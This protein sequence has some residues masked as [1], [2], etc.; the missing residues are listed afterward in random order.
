[1]AQEASVFEKLGGSEGL[2]SNTVYDIAEDELGFLWIGTKSGL[3]RFDGYDFDAVPLTYSVS[4]VPTTAAVLSLEVDKR[5]LLWIG[6]KAGG[7]M[8]YDRLDHTIR[9]YPFDDNKTVDWSTITIRSIYEDSRGW[10]W[11]G[12]FGGGAIVLDTDRKVQAHYCTYCNEERQ[13]KLSNDFV[14]DFAEDDNGDIYIA[15]A[16]RGLNRYSQDLGGVE[17]VHAPVAKDLNSFGKTLCFDSNGILWIGTE[18]NG[19]YTFD[20]GRDIWDVYLAQKDRL[21]SN[22]ITDIKEDR[23]GRLWVA[24]DGGGLNVYDPVSDVFRSI[25]YDPLRPNS[26]TTDAIYDLHFDRGDN[27]WIGTFNS[28]V[29]SLK[30]IQSPFWTDREYDM[31]RRKGLRSVLSIQEDDRNRV[32]L[33]TDGGGLF[34]FNTGDA[35]LNLRSGTDLIE[36]GSFTDVVTSILPDEDRGI[37]FGSFAS[38]LNYYDFTTRRIRQYVHDDTIATS[39]SHNNVWDIEM[40]ESGDLWIATLGGGL[41]YLAAGTSAFKHYPTLLPSVQIID[42]EM[43]KSNR[44]LWAATEAEGLYR[45][46]LSSM[47]VKAYRKDGAAD[48]RLRSDMLM[49]IFDDDR[50]DLWVVHAAGLDRIDASDGSITPIDLDQVFPMSSLRTVTQ[51]QEGY[52]W[53]ATADGIFRL[54]RDSGDLLDFGVD[55]SLDYNSYNPRAVHLLSDGRIIFGG[56]QSF[57]IVQPSAVE[58]NGNDAVPVMTD[59]KVAGESVAVGQYGDRVVMTSDLNAADAEVDLSYE[60]RSI[61]FEFSTTDYTAPS[62]NS[63]AYMLEGFDEDWQYTDA[64]TRSITYSSL[65]G[66]RYLFKLKSANSSGAWSDTVRTIKVNIKPPFWQTGFFIGLMAGILLLSVYLIYVFLLRRQKEKYREQALL[67]EKELLKR[68]QQILQLT[69]TS[70][71]KEVSLKKA[72]LNASVLQAAHKN[73]F[74][75]V[76]KNR[77]KKIKADADETAAKPL[78]SVINIIN[79]ELKQEDYWAK[80]QINFDQTFQNFIRVIENQHPILTSNDHR[81]CCF[82]KMKLNNREIAAILNITVSAVEQAKYRLKKKIGLEKAESLTKYLQQYHQ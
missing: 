20:Q 71:E 4:Q 59:L 69:N 49:S 37:W 54:D 77:I 21:S 47:E 40:D 5:G 35:P 80:F 13:E 61:T 38:G 60:D 1:M 30:A 10:I 31:E 51:D 75:N 57:S 39:I 67:Q 52:L 7:L 28:G 56:V 68:E 26:L 8:A 15:T 81:L 62:R 63:F 64:Q 16:G 27:L 41:E 33:G 42:I 65:K 22:I 32:W 11:I 23:A 17:E 78:R 73:E 14:F 25:Q 2:S 53:L 19:L 76:L 44:Y 48:N 18:G 70:L 66:G 50:G 3:F 24:S 45:L 82:I 55:P 12:T 72:E 58:L 9:R 6:L 34:Y 74:L 46:S 29:N 36:V 43:D 79:T